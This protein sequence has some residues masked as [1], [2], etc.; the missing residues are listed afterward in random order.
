M[1]KQ[2]SLLTAA[3]LLTIMACAPP[4]EPPPEID[5]EAERAALSEAANRYHEAGVSLD[6]DT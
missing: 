1:T 6:L 3:V 5:I 2:C 4:P